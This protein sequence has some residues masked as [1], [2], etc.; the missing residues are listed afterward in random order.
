M[1]YNCRSII[2]FAGFCVG[3]C[4][5][6]VYLILVSDFQ[7]LNSTEFSGDDLTV[8]HS[9][10]GYR[11]NFLSECCLYVSTYFASASCAPVER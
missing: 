9:I 10:S 6:F 3:R 8:V 5:C 7:L 1:I 11:G 2:S 4:M